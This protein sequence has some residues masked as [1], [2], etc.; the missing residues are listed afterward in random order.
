MSDSTITLCIIVALFVGL[1]VAL[2]PVGFILAL[3]L[4]LI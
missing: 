2:G 1:T 3:I 4:C